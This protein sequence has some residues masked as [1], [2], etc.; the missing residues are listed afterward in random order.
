MDT[1]A[2]PFAAPTRTARRAAVLAALVLLAA[3]PAAPAASAP[4]AGDGV[5]SL[6]AL[7]A[8]VGVQPV[9]YDPAQS[10]ACRRHASYYALTGHVGHE[11]LPEDPGYSAEGDRAAR[12]SNLAYG[13]SPFVG[14][15]DWAGAVYH[16]IAMLH[17]RL[18][19]SGYWA[20]NG[21]A[22]L[23]VL[24]AERGPAVSQLTAYPY[25]ADGQ[26]GLPISF[27]CNERPNPCSAFPGASAK[28]PMGSILSVQFDAPQ[29]SVDAATVDSATLTA[30]GSA[31][32]VVTAVQDAESG[33]I[34]PYLRGGLA[35][36]PRSPLKAGTWYMA[37]VTGTVSLSDV[38]AGVIEQPFDVTWRFQTGPVVLGVS[39][40][41]R[42]A[43][44]S[45]TRKGITRSVRRCAKLKKKATATRSAARR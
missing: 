9:R 30:D 10:A 3:V 11:E 41:S 12:T 21:I 17:P 29:D 36:L 34:A 25:P 13:D 2:V 4:S 42:S 27:G 20:E 38:A 40:S 6:N 5:R 44:C 22:C 26:Q 18:A 37:R 15:G 45:T 39:V 8:R 16:R 33:S 1:A 23:G 35:I 14:A 19:T 7:R 43:R 24:G 31:G 28:R 32:P